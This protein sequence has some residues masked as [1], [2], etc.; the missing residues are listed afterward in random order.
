MWGLRIAGAGI[1]A[2]PAAALRLAHFESVWWLAPTSRWRTAMLERMARPDPS[3]AVASEDKS[4][5]PQGLGFGIWAPGSRRG[6]RL[7][8]GDLAPLQAWRYL[9]STFAPASSSFFLIASASALLVPS[10]TGF[11]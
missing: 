3:P 7:P 8:W 10:F 11:G 2:P 4:K 1:A 5:T 9:T 6:T